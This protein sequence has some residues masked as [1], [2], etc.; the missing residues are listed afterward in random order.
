MKNSKRKKRTPFAIDRDGVIYIDIK[1]T[2]I[3]LMFLMIDG[4]TMYQWADDKRTFLTLEDAIKWYETELGFT[5]RQKTIDDYK[6]N[7]E[8]LISCRTRV[9][10]DEA[11]PLPKKDIQC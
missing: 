9:K 11:D 5:T 8:I 2:G 6:E 4:F 1:Y 3:N 7:L 10:S